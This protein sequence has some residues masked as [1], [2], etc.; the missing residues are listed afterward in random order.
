[1]GISSVSSYAEKYFE[2]EMLEATCTHVL[3]INPVNYESFEGMQKYGMC[4]EWEW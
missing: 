4:E 3:Y 2:N 1:M